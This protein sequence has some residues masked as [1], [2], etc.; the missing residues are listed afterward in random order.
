MKDIPR[1]ALWLGFAGLI[2][3]IFAAGL[4]LTPEPELSPG[5]FAWVYPTDS[6][7]ILA[8]YGTV[9]LSFM[10]GVLWGFASQAPKDDAPLGYGLSVLPALYVFFFCLPHVFSLSP[11]NLDSIRNLAIGFIALLLLDAFFSGRA[12]APVW[13]LKF[14]VMLTTVVV[15]ALGIG[16]FA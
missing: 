16:Y 7:A 15:V 2:P 10:S 12:L 9:I 4:A 5:E 14:R 8:G 11:S 3:F 6:Q 13:W 1:S